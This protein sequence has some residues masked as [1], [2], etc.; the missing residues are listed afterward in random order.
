MNL[1]IVR[2]GFMGDEDP[3]RQVDLGPE[4]LADPVACVPAEGVGCSFAI[5]AA[6]DDERRGCESRRDH[7]AEYAPGVADPQLSRKTI[8]AV[9]QIGQGVAL[10]N[11]INM[12]E[13]ED[14]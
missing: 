6:V 12:T 10:D 4:S 2:L 8:D 7:R 3:R 11:S 14:I 9:E 1:L 13:G 5:C